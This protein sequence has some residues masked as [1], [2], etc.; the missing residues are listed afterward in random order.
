MRVLVRRQ[1]Q[2]D[3]LV[4]RATGQPVHLVPG[5]LEQGDAPIGRQLED[6]PQPVVA[7]GTLGDVGGLDRDLGRHRLEHGLRPTT[8]SG[9]G[10]GPAGRGPVPPVDVRRSARFLAWCAAWYGRSSALGVGPRPSSPRRTRPPEPAVLPLPLRRTAP[11]RWL[12]PGISLPAGGGSRTSGP[13]GVS[14]TSTPRSG[15][16]VADSVGGGEVPRARAS[17]RCLSSS[18]TSPS[19]TVGQLWSVAA[20]SAR[21]GRPASSPKTSTSRRPRRASA[22]PHRV[23]GVQRQ[24]ALADRVVQHGDGG[25]RAKVVVHRGDEIGRHRRRRRTDHLGGPV[26]EVVDPGQRG[27]PTRPARRRSTRSSSGS[28]AAPGRTG[29][30]GAGTA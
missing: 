21:P 29:P 7:L 5:H 3:A 17:A 16:G 18:A 13:C 24:I 8:H 19:T 12:F 26:D 30:P 27:R 10:A 2:R 22:R 6:L 11:L 23:S 9:S 28:A 1:L 15:K 14:A 4:D 25:R 20:H